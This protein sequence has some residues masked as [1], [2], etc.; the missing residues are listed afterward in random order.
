[1]KFLSYD[2]TFGQLLLKLCYSCYLNLLWFICCI[3]NCYNRR[4]NHG[5]VPCVF[6]SR[7]R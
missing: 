5:V 1:M 2:S 4:V 3:P 6:E 7:Q